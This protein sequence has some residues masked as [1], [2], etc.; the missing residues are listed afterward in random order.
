MTYPPGQQGPWGPQW[1]QGQQQWGSGRPPQQPQQQ[2]G[3]PPTSNPGWGGPPPQQGQW[4]AQPPSP[5]QNPNPWGAPPQQYAMPPQA[6]KSNRGKWIA[7]VGG[8][9]AVVAVA[10][11]LALT[12]GGGKY[13]GE[14][15]PALPGEFDGWSQGESLFGMS[16]YEKGGSSLTVIEF[17]AP[18]DEEIDDADDLQVFDEM[19]EVDVEETNPARGVH[20]VTASQYGTSCAIVYEDRAGFF[21]GGDASQSTVED[22]AVALAKSA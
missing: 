5:N 12:L 16:L 14:T 1:Q 4:G 15:R 21:V 22:A 18:G 8:V 9:V 19:P 13:A 6:P 3:Q 2:W 11:V 20:C 7:I 10:L 17:D